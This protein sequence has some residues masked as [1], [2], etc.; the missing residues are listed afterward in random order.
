IKPGPYPWGNGHNAWRQAHIHFSL[1]GR[2]IGQRLVT[3]MF[4]P[5]DPWAP[6]DPIFMAVRDERARNR[7]VA[8]LSVHDSE[9]N[10]AVGYNFD[11]FLRGPAATP[12][13]ERF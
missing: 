5:G 13:E 4:F 2:A 7:M 11:V 8:G 9:E 3:Q 1:M 6:Y 10:W 12:I